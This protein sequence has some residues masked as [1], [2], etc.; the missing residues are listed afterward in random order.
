MAIVAAMTTI[1]LTFWHEEW[2][3][4]LPT[5]RP[6]DLTQPSIGSPVSLP[7]IIDTYRAGRPVLLHFFN[8]ACPCSRFNLAHVAALMRDH[9][10][11]IEFVA[12]VQSTTAATDD[13]L[14]HLAGD[15]VMPSF[16]DQDDKLART[17][18]V[19]ATPQA[20]LVSA[21]GRLFFR[22][23]YNTSR[24]C[25]ARQT[26]FAR[27]AIEALLAGRPYEPPSAAEVAYGCELAAAER[28]ASEVKLT[29]KPLSA[30]KSDEE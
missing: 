19:Y 28:S 3:Y 22:G 5:P 10:S 18:G 21:D 20:V 30:A 12:V 11:K 25:K 15:C 27:L 26:Q 7:A 13:G 14:C 6:N 17:L 29:D 2:R 23:N 4:R 8:P 16:V 9:G 1:G 24:Y